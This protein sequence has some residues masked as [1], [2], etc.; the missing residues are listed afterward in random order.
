MEINGIIDE[1]AVER[2]VSSTRQED[3]DENGFDP[4]LFL[5]ILTSQLQNQNP[6]D[7]VDTTEIASQ[8]ATM[9]QVEQTTRQ[10]SYLEDLVNSNNTSS[11]NF[12]LMNETLLEIKDLLE[13]Q[14]A[15]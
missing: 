7:A 11:A 15:S 13:Q 6:F 3:V 8:Q 9:A 4:N 1:L 5:K 2:A 12:T 10:T 14:S